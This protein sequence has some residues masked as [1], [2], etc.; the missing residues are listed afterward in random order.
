MT[1]CKFVKL[2]KVYIL[3][4]GFLRFQLSPRNVIYYV[5]DPMQVFQLVKLYI[6]NT[7]RNIQKKHQ[8]CNINDLVEFVGLA[9]V[10][11]LSIEFQ[12]KNI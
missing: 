7:Y 6:L 4:V 5:N 10:N 3:P 2:A 9:N 11:T 1:Q 12:Q 8:Q